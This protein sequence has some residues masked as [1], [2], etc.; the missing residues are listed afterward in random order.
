MSC[1]RFTPVLIADSCNLC[2]TCSRTKISRNRHAGRQSMY[3]AH[4]GLAVRRR[5]LDL[6]G[7]A[8]FVYT[9]GRAGARRHCLP[10][11]RM[12][13]GMT[14]HGR[15]RLDPDNASRVQTTAV[16]PRAADSDW[17]QR[18]AIDSLITSICLSYRQ[19]AAILSH[20]SSC[21][22]SQPRPQTIISGRDAGWSPAADAR[23]YS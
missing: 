16:A 8:T 22:P 14:R 18:L 2:A 19:G 6:V 7:A 23:G 11:R 4:I 15:A 12:T 20:P 1:S 5:Q 3:K 9:D 13:P 10:R 17:V 21:L